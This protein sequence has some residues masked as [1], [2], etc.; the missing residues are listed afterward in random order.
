MLTPLYPGRYHQVR[1]NLNNIVLA[2]DLSK[3]QWASLLGGTVS[4]IISRGF[5]FRFGVVP[6]GTSEEGTCFLEELCQVF[7]LN[8]P[9]LDVAMKAARLFYHLSDNFEPMLVLKFLGNVSSPTPL[10]QTAKKDLPPPP[11]HP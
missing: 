7:V 2:V 3:T 11:I 6:I 5:P 1:R 9:F 4:N 10:L 8:L